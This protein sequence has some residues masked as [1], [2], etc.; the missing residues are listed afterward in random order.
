MILSLPR[1]ACPPSPLRGTSPRGGRVPA[2]RRRSGTGANRQNRAVSKIQRQTKRTKLLPHRGRCRQTE[3]GHP[4]PITTLLLADHQSF[5]ASAPHMRWCTTSSAST[6]TTATVRPVSVINSTSKALCS[7]LGQVACHESRPPLDMQD[8]SV[9]Q[10]GFPCRRVH[11]FLD[12]ETN[13]RSQAE[14]PRAD[15]TLAHSTTSSRA[16]RKSSFPT[17]EG[18]PKGRKGDRSLYSTTYTVLSPGLEAPAYSNS[19]PDH[20]N[21]DLSRTY[22]SPSNGIDRHRTRPSRTLKIAPSSNAGRWLSS[23]DC[24]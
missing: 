16:E 18:V 15:A 17:G 11:F 19:T 13:Q 22:R 20:P 14:K 10:S 7:C 8:G 2:P 21:T 3:G 1:V 6:V 12:E 5:T 23:S 24:K 4:P 9:S